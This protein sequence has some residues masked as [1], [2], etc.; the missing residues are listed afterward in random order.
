MPHYIE[1]QQRRYLEDQQRRLHHQINIDAQRELL[2]R[3]G[4]PPSHPLVAGEIPIHPELL[5]HLHFD[6]PYRTTLPLNPDDFQRFLP[7]MQRSGMRSAFPLSTNDLT[8]LQREQEAAAAMAAAKVR[9]QKSYKEP[10]FSSLQYEAARKEVKGG[11]S[12]STDHRAVADKKSR[13]FSKFSSSGGGGGWFGAKEDGREEQGRSKA[14]QHWFMKEKTMQSLPPSLGTEYAV[15]GNQL[16]RGDKDRS[17]FGMILKDKFQKNPNMYFPETRTPSRTPDHKGSKKDKV[18]E[19]SDTDTLIHNMSEGSFDK[20]SSLS[21][22]RSAGSRESNRSSGKSSLSHDSINGTPELKRETRESIT[23]PKKMSNTAVHL[24]SNPSVILNKKTIRNYTPKES[25][26]MLRQ[27]EEGRHGSLDKKSSR[28]SARS[29]AQKRSASATSAATDTGK[30]NNNPPRQSSMDKL[31]DDFHRNLPPPPT[32]DDSVS[33]FS[34]VD[35]IFSGSAALDTSVKRVDLTGNNRVSKIGTVTSQTSHWSVASSVA[36]F[37]YQSANKANNNGGNSNNSKL[38]KGHQS[39]KSSNQT[40]DLGGNDAAVRRR[41]SSVSPLS[42]VGEDSPRQVGPRVPPEGAPSPEAARPFVQRIE[43]K[44]DVHAAMER[45]LNNKTRGKEVSSQNE[46]NDRGKK[47]SSVGAERKETTAADDSND[48]ELAMLRKL[49]SEGRIAGLNDKPPAFKPPTPP[50]PSKAGA[51]KSAAAAKKSKAPVPAISAAAGSLPNPPPTTKLSS[52]DNANKDA[53]KTNNKASE[54]NNKQSNKRT[55]DSK[56]ATSGDRPRKSR[57]APSPPVNTSSG[58]SKKSTPPLDEYIKPPP[59]TAE[60]KFTGVRRI[61]SVEDL[62]ERTGG[63]GE[64]A[65]A[66][67]RRR[68]QKSDAVRRS[69]SMHKQKGI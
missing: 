7:E 48:D 41:I 28:K 66:D 53:S 40:T 12:H 69:T 64:R 37:D 54:T 16:A 65:E 21:W 60:I 67:V 26:N 13:V 10:S 35:S 24:A 14:K 56:K 6:V 19:L 20:N 4:F 11:R 61:H 1:E 8:L 38:K 59:N 23:T 46:V 25:S 49:I 2:I 29:P 45:P 44:G 15:D 27:F 36:S 55:P 17:S 18:D 51:D 34:D 43:V 9:R 32:K 39:S 5:G 33:P 3:R 63:G 57:E 47:A 62:N 22:S 52:R 31:I 50:S 58:L 68:D 30:T 42:A